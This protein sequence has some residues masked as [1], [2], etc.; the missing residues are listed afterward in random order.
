MQV[1]GY[2]DGG[3][4][5]YGWGCTYRNVQTILTAARSQSADSSFVLA[6]E[7][8][9]PTADFDA[10]VRRVR[11]SSEEF[12]VV[13]AGRADA[14]RIEPHHAGEYLKQVH[15]MGSFG[16]LVLPPGG[17]ADAVL[18]STDAA[19]YASAPHC[20]LSTEGADATALATAVLAHFAE[21]SALPMICDDGSYSYVLLDAQAA[22]ESGSALGDS[23]AEVGAEPRAPLGLGGVRVLVGDPHRPRP[24]QPPPP[25]DEMCALLMAM[26]FAEGAAAAALRL[27]GR[28]IEQASEMLL[29]NADAVEAEA[30]AHKEEGQ[31]AETDDAAPDDAAPDD[32]APDDAAALAPI[33]PKWRPFTEFLGERGWAMLFPYRGDV[34]ASAA[35]A[36]TAYDLCDV[37]V[38]ESEAARAA[39]RADY[40]QR[41]AQKRAQ[42]LLTDADSG[43]RLFLGPGQVAASADDLSFL[44]VT[45]VLSVLAEPPEIAVAAEACQFVQVEDTVDAEKHMD[46]ALPVAVSAMARW[47]D[48][49][50]SVLVH[51]ASGISRSATVS[52]AYLARARG[53][54]AI[55]AYA[56]VHELRPCV[57]PNDS[58]FRALCRA[59][60]SAEVTAEDMA[61]YHAFQLVS[62]LAWCD[63]TLPAAKEALRDASGD[64]EQAASAIIEGFE[65]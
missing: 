27:A 42:L 16:A 55:E 4:D 9:S 1:F 8:D 57:N 31:A 54:S 11:D 12:G 2:G 18:V 15:G 6:P 47:I 63:V 36:S 48:A 35:P 13:H 25:A 44:G 5:D 60:G 51:C 29:T 50:E 21:P 32:A 10:I 14:R 26:G 7:A 34:P 62:Q 65:A 58:F 49:G 38:S 41:P 3:H 30:A 52:M 45:R 23:W 39:W 20:R 59:D 53:I 46:A 28:D 61:S 43:G 40:E 24:P 64:A 56:A 33:V 19:V 22:G 17:A 37:A